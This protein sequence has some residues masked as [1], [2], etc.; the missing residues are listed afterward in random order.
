MNWEA[1]GAIS[2]IVGTLALLVTLVYLAIQIRNNT[3]AVK[4]ENVHRVTDS[5]N[6]LNTLLASDSELAD[7]WLRGSRNYQDLTDTEKGR[8]GFI[9]LAAFRIYD[10]LYYQIQRATSDDELWKAELDTIRWV[11]SFPG[12]RMWWRQQRFNFSPG[13]KEYIDDIVF[14]SDRDDLK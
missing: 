9:Q 12:M 7:L 8:F 6:A 5:F 2:G 4:S 1:I 3:N 11:F 13:F 14:E 10:S